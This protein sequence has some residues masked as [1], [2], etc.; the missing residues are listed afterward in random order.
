M[1]R[2]CYYPSPY[3]RR[4]VS[5]GSLA[6]WLRG[7][8]SKAHIAEVVAVE[9]KVLPVDYKTILSDVTVLVKLKSPLEKA[10][11]DCRTS[12]GFNREGNCL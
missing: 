3:E 10:R 12:F 7:R 1:P 8:P 9:T 11:P 2:H 6:R 5:R 4:S